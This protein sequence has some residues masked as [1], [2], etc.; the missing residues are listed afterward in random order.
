MEIAE[1]NWSDDS[2]LW[3]LEYGNDGTDRKASARIYLQMRLEDYTPEEINP[4]TIP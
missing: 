4:V 1:F 3:E 2:A